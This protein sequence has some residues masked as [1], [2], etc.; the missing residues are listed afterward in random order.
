MWSWPGCR[1][2]PTRSRSG[3]TPRRSACPISIVRS[4]APVGS[5]PPGG[6]CVSRAWTTWPAG[7]GVSCRGPAPCRSSQGRPVLVP[8]V[9][10]Q[11]RSTVIGWTLGGAV[12][13]HITRALPDLVRRLVVA[14]ANPGG[15][16]PGAPDPNPKGR[17]TMAKPEVR[18]DGLVFIFFP[19]ADTGRAAGVRLL[20]RVATRLA[21]GFPDMSE[22]AAVG[23]IAAMAK[24]ATIRFEQVRADLASIR[25]P[26]LYATGMQDVMI[27]APAAYT[28]VQHLPNATLAAYSNAGH[29][30][31]FQPLPARQGIR[32]PGHA[33]HG[34]PS[35]PRPG[36]T[37]P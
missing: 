7:G 5:A 28:A 35:G 29:A 23:Q 30:F 31:V 15:T 20:G 11:R 24:G 14:A 33:F 2:E 12:A 10:G 16:V 4:W 8:E 34:Q 1:S 18:G 27:P 17:T 32:R 37:Y 22:T 3:R 9:L 36:T 25:R 6:P 21:N 26:V 13:Q 19:E